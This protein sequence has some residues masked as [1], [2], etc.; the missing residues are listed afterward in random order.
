MYAFQITISRKQTITE[1]PV[2]L[3]TII[4]HGFIHRLTLLVSITLL[5][6]QNIASL[7]EL[8]MYDFCVLLAT[9]AE[10]SS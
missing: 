2:L 1:I 6:L 4:N 3:Y 5:V 9:P 8:D 7:L 10:N